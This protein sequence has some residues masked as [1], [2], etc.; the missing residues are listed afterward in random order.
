[1]VIDDET[2]IAKIKGMEISPLWKDLNS[3]A[4]SSGFVF[5]DENGEE[6]PAGSAMKRFMKKLK[7][8][9]IK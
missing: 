1:M 7:Q 8:R 6:Y 4:M 2:A 3:F 5:E 9:C